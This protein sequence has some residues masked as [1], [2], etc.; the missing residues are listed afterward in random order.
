ML[1]IFKFQITFNSVEI[2]NYKIIVRRYLPIQQNRSAE[3]ALG[4]RE[5]KRREEKR[6]EEKR[7]EEKRREE[8]R[9]AERGSALFGGTPV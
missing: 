3:S 6:R 5:E 9:E 8:K 1:I 4:R 2:I 7:R